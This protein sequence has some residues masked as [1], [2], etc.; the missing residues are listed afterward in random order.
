MARKTFRE[1]RARLDG[2]LRMMVS[3]FYEFSV[4]LENRVLNLSSPTSKAYSSAIILSNAREG[5]TRLTTKGYIIIITL[6]LYIATSMRPNIYR[7]FLIL[8]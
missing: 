6:L 4:H 3:T 5:A 8:T 2:S 7:A 1:Y